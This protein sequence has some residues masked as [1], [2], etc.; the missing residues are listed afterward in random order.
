MDNK[1]GKAAIVSQRISLR[2]EAMLESIV[3]SV[4]LTRKP[5]VIHFE[6]EEEARRAAERLTQIAERLS[7]K[8]EQE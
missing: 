3:S 8:S 1:F 7:A 6:T 4:F 5:I 2:N